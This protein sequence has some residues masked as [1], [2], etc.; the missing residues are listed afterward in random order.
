[1][2]RIL[3]LD[4]GTKRTGVAVTD[5]LQII[6]TALETVR[7]HRLLAFLSDYCVREKVELF[8]LG[9]PKNLDLGDTKTTQAVR[10][11][12]KQLKKQFPQI[13]VCLTDE[14]FTS[15]IALDAM[16]RGG[17]KKKDRREK[18]AVD[19]IS[20]VLILQSYLEARENRRG[21]ALS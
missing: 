16:R 21:S 6:A 14:R 9:M 11:L 19:K 10:T 1:M 5:S 3:A 7:T 17:M 12:E 15:K 4:Y 13:P 20:A 2:G 18:G 8:V